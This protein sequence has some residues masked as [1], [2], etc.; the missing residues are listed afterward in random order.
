MLGLDSAVLLQCFTYF[1][2]RFTSLQQKSLVA[3]ADMDLVISKR[4]G[5]DN[6]D[7]CEDLNKIVYGLCTNRDN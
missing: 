2:I 1:D 3:I 6:Q 4:K 5:N 7:C